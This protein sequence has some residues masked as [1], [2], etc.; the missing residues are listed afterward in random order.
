VEA[1]FAS[2]GAKKSVAGE[3][4]FYI[5]TTSTRR[6]FSRPESVELL[7]TGRAG[8]YP[9]AV[10]RLRSMPW[11]ASQFKT[12]FARSS[13]SFRLASALPLLSV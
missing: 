6:F 5:R 1:N 11:S 7:P 8:P 3:S 2:P 13:E 12:A 4:V 9:F 10:R